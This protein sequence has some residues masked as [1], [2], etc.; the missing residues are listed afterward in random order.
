MLFA[1]GLLD[2]IMYLI[3][4]FELLICCMETFSTVKKK[5]LFAAFSLFT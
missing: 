3:V 2:Y 1:T 5:F 4:L